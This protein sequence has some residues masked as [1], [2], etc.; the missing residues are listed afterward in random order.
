[1]WKSRQDL[2]ESYRWAVSISRSPDPS[3]SMTRAPQCWMCLF[4]CLFVCLSVCLSVYSFVLVEVHLKTGFNGLILVARS[5]CDSVWIS[6]DRF[7]ETAWLARAPD[8]RLFPRRLSCCCSFGLLCSNAPLLLH[9]TK[10]KTHQSIAAHNTNTE[11][12]N[13]AQNCKAQ[14]YA[15]LLSH[16]H[17]ASWASKSMNRWR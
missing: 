9:H 2:F 13:T 16:C 7:P 15:A 17:S 3:R 4:V 12:H 10:S 8:L 6:H 5:S 11:L 14:H 1:M